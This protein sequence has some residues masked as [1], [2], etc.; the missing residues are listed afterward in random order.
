MSTIRRHGVAFHLIPTP[1][2]VLWLEVIRESDGAVLHCEELDDQPDEL[3]E[4]VEK[5]FDDIVRGRVD[6]ID[7]PA[8]RGCGNRRR[9]ART[10][11]DGWVLPDYLV[12]WHFVLCVVCAARLEQ[13]SPW[14]RDYLAE[15]VGP[16]PDDGGD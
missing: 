1:G 2:E 4:A 9:V 6:G 11:H 14:M 3:A 7:I 15:R 5:W 13:A 10:D 8:C 16:I 12:E